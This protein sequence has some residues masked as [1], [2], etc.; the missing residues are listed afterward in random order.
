MANALDHIILIGFAISGSI[1]TPPEDL[2]PV[3]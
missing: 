3:T 2:D 1:S